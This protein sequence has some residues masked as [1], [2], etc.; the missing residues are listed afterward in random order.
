MTQHKLTKKGEGPSDDP[1]TSLE[2]SI[3]SEPSETLTKKG[4]YYLSGEIESGSFSTISQDI[5]S[6]HLDPKWKDDI[7]LIIN[8]PGG[9][10]SEAWALIDLLD[11]VRM[12][13][14]TIGMGMCCSMG[15]ILLASGTPGKRTVTPNCSIMIHGASISWAAGNQQQIATVVKDMTNEFNRHIRFWINHSKYLSKE[16]IEKKF[17]S[18]FDNWFTA[19]EALKHGIVDHMIDTKMFKKRKS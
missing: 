12:D 1:S 2:I 16:E 8:S 13:V 6:K 15:A 18:G 9:E 14:R 3:A 7:Q 4:I 11:W 19:E 17:L 5:L 10:T